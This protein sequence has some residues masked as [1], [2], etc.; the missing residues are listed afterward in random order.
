MT[1]LSHTL[2]KCNV[3]NINNELTVQRDKRETDSE[4]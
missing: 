4:I 3:Q 2:F 1:H